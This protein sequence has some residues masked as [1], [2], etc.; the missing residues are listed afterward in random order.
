MDRSLT[1]LFQTN[2]FRLRLNVRNDFLQI[3]LIIDSSD[4]LF[5]FLK[6]T[7]SS[8]LFSSEANLPKFRSP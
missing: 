7:Q 4:I 1:G 8:I 5:Y 3:L 6:A 2:F